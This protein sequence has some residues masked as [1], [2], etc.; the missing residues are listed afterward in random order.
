MS[1]LLACCGG[2]MEIGVGAGVGI[3]GNI[4]VVLATSGRVAGSSV[5][6]PA[7]LSFVEASAAP[8]PAALTTH[9]ARGKFLDLLLLLRQL[10]LQL[11]DIIPTFILGPRYADQA[12][13]RP[14]NVPRRAKL[15]ILMLLFSS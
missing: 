12:Q 15:L 10:R 5:R 4:G 9:P 8:A 7:A 1:L 14:A 11:G 2:V 3:V 13:A 6:G